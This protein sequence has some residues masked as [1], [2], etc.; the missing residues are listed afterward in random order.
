MEPHTV[1]NI[2]TFSTLFH[3]PLHCVSTSC[4]VFVRRS[5]YK[6]FELRSLLYVY[7]FQGLLSFVGISHCCSSSYDCCNG[8]ARERVLLWV[9]FSFSFCFSASASIS[10]CAKRTCVAPVYIGVCSLVECSMAGWW[11]AGLLDWSEWLGVLAWLAGLLTL[12]HACWLHWVCVRLA[13]VCFVASPT[14]SLSVAIVLSAA[15]SPFWRILS[16]RLLR[17]SHCDHSAA[18]LLS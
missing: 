11:V 13:L 14:Q 12:L 6:S 2:L 7:V 1:W 17:C 16:M 8:E 10:D 4:Y 3:L 15:Q 9:F 18:R 5:T